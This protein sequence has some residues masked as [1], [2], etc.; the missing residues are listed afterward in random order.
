MKGLKDLSF[1]YSVSERIS[2]STVHLKSAI[3]TA[4]NFST[5]RLPSGKWG[6]YHGACLLATT[7][8]QE[9]CET[10]LL[11]LSKGPNHRNSRARLQPQKSE[12]SARARQIASLAIATPSYSGDGNSK[13]SHA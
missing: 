12:L 8:S 2:P 1:S 3:L 6:I 4:M 9:T 5:Q 11:G 7:A 13:A 10:V